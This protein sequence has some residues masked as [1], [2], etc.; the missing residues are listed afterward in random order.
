[1]FTV[2]RNVVFDYSTKFHVEYVE[3]KKDDVVVLSMFIVRQWNEVFGFHIGIA[4]FDTL[5]DAVDYIDS[6]HGKG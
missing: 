3:R 1:M 6:L 5:V 2:D 4:D